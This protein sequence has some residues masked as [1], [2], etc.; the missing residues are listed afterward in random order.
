MSS[1]VVTVAE[2]AA[3]F[4]VRPATIRRWIRVGKLPT[5][6]YPGGHYRIP[7]TALVGAPP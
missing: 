2:A 7:R 6:P 1:D 4:G 5:A 3:H